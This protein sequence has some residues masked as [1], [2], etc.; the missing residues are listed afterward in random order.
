MRGLT[1][2]FDRRSLI[3]STG[4]TASLRLLLEKL[5]C[6]HHIHLSLTPFRPKRSPHKSYRQV[7]DGG[8][9]HWQGSGEQYQGWLESKCY[10]I[11]LCPLR[12]SDMK[13]EGEADVERLSKPTSG[14]NLGLT[15]LFSSPQ[16]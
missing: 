3:G 13:T 12:S 2:P 8:G 9:M 14:E 5:C 10:R 1:L 4:T 7:L 6:L 11:E 16:D 15:M